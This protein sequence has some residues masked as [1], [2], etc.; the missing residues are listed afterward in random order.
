MHAM[1]HS[2]E[3]LSVGVFGIGAG[4]FKLVRQHFGE[5]E[6]SAFLHLVVGCTFFFCHTFGIGYRAPSASDPHPKKSL[7]MLAEEG[8][9]LQFLSIIETVVVEI[10]SGMRVGHQKVIAAVFEKFG[11]H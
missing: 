9:V 7:G 2:V 5:I 4:F 10:E 1:K 11:N 3:I 8:K 6:W